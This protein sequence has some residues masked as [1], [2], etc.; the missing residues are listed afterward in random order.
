MSQRN[1]CDF[2]VVRCNLQFHLQSRINSF[3]AHADTQGVHSLTD[4][5]PVQ[6]KLQQEAKLPLG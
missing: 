5:L 1:K 3:A 2:R 4:M 6:S